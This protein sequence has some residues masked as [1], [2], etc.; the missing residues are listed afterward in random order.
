MAHLSLKR[1]HQQRVLSCV[2][3]KIMKINAPMF[4]I[5]TLI[6]ALSL[7]AGR[8]KAAVNQ[9]ESYPMV[10]DAPW[11]LQGL[12]QSIIKVNKIGPGMQFQFERVQE[13]KPVSKLDQPGQMFCLTHLKVV[14]MQS[15]RVTDNVRLRYQVKVNGDFAKAGAAYNVEFEPLR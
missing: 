14:E 4:F 2:L 3:R 5:N 1:Q 11:V 8:A 12:Q 10:C 13:Y 9:A 15:Q 6:I 7:M